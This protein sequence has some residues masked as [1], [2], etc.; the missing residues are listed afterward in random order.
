MKTKM[1]FKQSLLSVLVV[2]AVVGATIPW[3]NYLPQSIPPTEQITYFQEDAQR[4]AL[5]VDAQK[6]I[7]PELLADIAEHNLVVG[8]EEGIEQQ[9]D[10]THYY[11]EQI[12]SPESDEAQ[13]PTLKEEV[14]AIHNAHQA[15]LYMMVSPLLFAFDST[16]IAAH[17]H[18]ALN[19]SARFIQ[20]EALDKDTL[21]Q[22]VGYADT[23]GNA[24]YNSKLAQRRAQQVSEY[25][26]SQGVDEKLLSVVSL[27]EVP[28]GEGLKANA[29]RV[30][31]QRYQ[32]ETST[33]VAQH[34]QQISALRESL[35]Q[36]ARALAANTESGTPQEIANTK[37]VDAE[38]VMV[39]LATVEL[40]DTHDSVEVEVAATSPDLQANPDQGISS[41]EQTLTQP[42]NDAQTQAVPVPIDHVEEVLTTPQSMALTSAMAL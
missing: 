31:I 16:D 3:E 41:D 8:L 29:R 18:E 10:D 13:A 35:T 12:L 40:A 24:I 20:D 23:T 7:D 25:L 4:D 21:W 28:K 5:A 30:E 42:E 33:L 27:G 36:R 26:I 39:T 37:V 11:S 14:L 9:A 34:Q 22:V 15:P 6:E 38:P 32:A 19:D 2:S 1:T 17:Y